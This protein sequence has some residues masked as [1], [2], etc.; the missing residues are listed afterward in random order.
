VNLQIEDL[1]RVRSL[2]TRRVPLAVFAGCHCGLQNAVGVVVRDAL[3]PAP[4]LHRV[5]P[6]RRSASGLHGSLG[7]CFTLS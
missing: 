1:T 4:A 3:L 6:S 5:R 2:Q 7:A